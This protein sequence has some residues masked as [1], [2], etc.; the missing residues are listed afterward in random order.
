MWLFCLSGEYLAGC[1]LT[2]SFFN[3]IKNGFRY[4][5]HLLHV[6]TGGEPTMTEKTSINEKIAQLIAEEE[7][8]EAAQTWQGHLKRIWQATN[9][10]QALKEALLRFM[11]GLSKK[12]LFTLFLMIAFVFMLTFSVII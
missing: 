8:R 2:A 1:A 9:R 4:N 5:T 10:R 11:K 6:A 12:A 3:H 7:A